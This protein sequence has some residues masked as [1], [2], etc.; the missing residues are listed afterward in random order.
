MWVLFSIF[1]AENIS[2][3]SKVKG[4]SCIQLYMGKCVDRNRN[5]ARDRDRD[6]YEDEV[7]DRDRNRDRD[8]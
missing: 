8:I 1:S 6:G 5:R 4:K 3:I 2:L 7:G